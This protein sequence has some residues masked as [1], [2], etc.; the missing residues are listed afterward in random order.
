MSDQDRLNEL[1]TGTPDWDD[2][3]EET[4]VQRSVAPSTPWSMTFDHEGKPKQTGAHEQWGIMAGGT[5]FQPVG[6]TVRSVPPA[7]YTPLMTP[8]GFFLSKS[9]IVSDGI[10]QLPD[11]ATEEVLREAQSFWDSEAKYRKHGL[12]FKRGVLLWGQPGSGKT[13]TVK[14]LMSEL[15]KRGGIVLLG[16]DVGGIITGLKVIRGI[17]PS[18][19]IIVVMEDIDEI[20]NRYGEAIV[21]SVLDGEHNVDNVLNVA[22]TNFPE[23]LGARIVNR[24][25]R[26]D[27]TIF[28]DMPGE[29]ARREYIQKKTSDGLS[30][31]D[32]QQW[33]QDTEKMSIAHIRELIAAVYCLNQSYPEVVDRLKKMMYRPEGT[34]DE[35]FLTKTK[36]P[37]F[38][39]KV[40]GGKDPS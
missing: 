31:T 21:L 34:K 35:G 16:D 28:V 18:R 39:T 38:S 32:L 9:P 11:M 1:L 5:V 6:P 4:S 13:V 37:G 40:W 26:F 24:P 8:S 29:A 36:T 3:D 15:I 25:S 10:Y 33:V 20:I 30:S 22:T 27:R 23:R 17:E 12:L 2:D 19:N 7:V 14:V